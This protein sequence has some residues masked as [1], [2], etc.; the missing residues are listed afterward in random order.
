L[1]QA[2]AGLPGVAI[3]PEHF[4][5]LNHTNFQAA[6]ASVF[7]ASFG[8]IDSTFPARQIQFAV[9]LYW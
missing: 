2:P 9:K 3:R 4:N 1:H 8:V 5:L 7:S 6:N